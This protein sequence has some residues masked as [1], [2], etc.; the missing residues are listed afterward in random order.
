MSKFSTLKMYTKRTAK[1]GEAT[2]LYDHQVKLLDGGELDLSSRRGK[3][4]L[5]VNTASK[6]GYTPQYEGLQ[7]LYQRYS[8]RGLQ[9]LGSPSGDFAGQE[10]DDADG[11]RRLLPEELR[12]D[13]PADRADLGAGRA[14][15]AVE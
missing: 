3:P 4:T 10:Y 6:C 1:L 11:D 14:R 5:F 13:L 7:A 2:D 8:D 15:P 12:R 9:V